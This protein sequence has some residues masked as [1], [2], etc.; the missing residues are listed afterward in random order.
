[1]P[2]NEKAEFDDPIIINAVAVI[3]STIPIVR[4]RRTNDVT[5]FL[6][7]SVI[8]DRLYESSAKIT[9]LAPIMEYVFI[10]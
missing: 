5:S 1:M 9:M 10:N 4:K 3:S 7:C 8:I 2:C 6:R